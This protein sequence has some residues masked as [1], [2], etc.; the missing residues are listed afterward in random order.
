MSGV[1]AVLDLAHRSERAVE[2]QLRSE[3]VDDLLERGRDDVHAL[4]ALFVLTREGEGVAVDEGLQ[5]WFERRGDELEERQIG[6]TVGVRRAR[7]EIEAFLI[8]ELA[9]GESLRHMMQRAH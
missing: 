3:R 6:C 8:R 7:G 9:Y 4:T 5:H 1:D 2:V